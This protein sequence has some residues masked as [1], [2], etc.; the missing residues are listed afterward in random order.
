[1]KKILLS[2]VAVCGLLSCNKDQGPDVWKSEAYDYAGRFLFEM[3]YEGDQTKN[4]PVKFG[5]HELRIFN[6]AE[7]KAN[8]IWLEDHNLK[9][10]LKSLFVISGKSTSFKSATEGFD[11]QTDNLYAIG[12]PKKEEGIDAPTVEGQTVSVPRKKIRAEILDAKIEPKA[13]KTRGGNMADK[14]HIKVRLYHGKAH[15][16]SVQKPKE[17]WEKPNVPEYKWLFKRAESTGEFVDA[18][19]SGHRFT[20][21]AEDE[22]H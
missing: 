21:F 15:F 18:T 1:M 17:E 20:G 14:L 10:A 11:A 22:Y 5:S 9:I 16:A 13:Y 4:P 6:S 7:N 19:I 3:V 8:E 12:A 2:L